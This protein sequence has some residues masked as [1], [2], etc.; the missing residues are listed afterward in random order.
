MLFMERFYCQSFNISIVILFEFCIV[1]QDVFLMLF[2]EHFYCQSLNISIVILFV[3]L[4][5]RGIST[6]MLFAFPE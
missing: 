5:S 6:I 1:N 2:M 3:C 4:D